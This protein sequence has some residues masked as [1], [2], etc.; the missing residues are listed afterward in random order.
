MANT[1]QH[2]IAKRLVSALAL[3]VWACFIFGFSGQNGGESGGLSARVAET[4]VSFGDLLTGVSTTGAA[5]DAAVEALQFP[6]RKA[7]HMT[8][9]AILAVLALVQLRLWPA[10][11]GNESQLRRAVGLAWG[12]AVLYAATDEI[13]QLFVPGRAGLFTDVMIDATGAALGLLLA[14]TIIVLRTQRK[15]TP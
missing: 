15:R 7:A 13:H 12:F 2:I 11:N 6:I 3:V 1:P 9:Y 14:A 10:F 8:E 5:L 4:L